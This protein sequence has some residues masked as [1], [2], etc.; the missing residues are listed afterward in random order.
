MRD[1]LFFEGKHGIA[2]LILREIPSR[3]L[4]YVVLQ[5]PMENSVRELAEEC[6]TFCT[7]AGAEHVFCCYETPVPGWQIAAQ[8]E[9]WDFSRSDRA[10]QLCAGLR[11]EPVTASTSAVYRSAYQTAFAPVWFAKRCDETDLERMVKS[12]TAYLIYEKAALIGL[13]EWCGAELASVAVT[14]AGRGRGMA[15][16]QKLL[17]AAP[18]ERLFLQTVSVNY[19]AA[20]LYQ[21]AG[22]RRGPVQAYWTASA[23]SCG[24]LQLPPTKEK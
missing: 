1:I 20:R 7:L 6:R 16:L 9:R 21:A 10:E 18:A 22:F 19:A 2:S 14:P 15:V 24:R 13:G 3:R 12:G 17:E 4:A 23:E 8:L 11:I 5:C